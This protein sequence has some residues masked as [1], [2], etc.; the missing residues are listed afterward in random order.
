MT[1]LPVAFS[2]LFDSAVS[3]AAK[4]C[5]W[6]IPMLATAGATAYISYI[7]SQKSNT[8]LVV[9]QQRL[10][11]LQQFRSSG[12]ELDQGLSAMSD[13]LVDGSGLDEAR[14][15]M[16]GA[17]TKNI[18]DAVAIRHLLGP[19][20]DTYIAGLARLRQVVDKTNDV[21]AGRDLWQTSIDLM[22]ER[23]TLLSSAQVEALRADQT[24]K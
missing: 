12:A 16:R 13:A 18:A 21:H 5:A 22:V 20:A 17:I 9:Q 8:A 1:T 19:K 10:N 3:G 24:A 11:D 15:Q 4:A 6:L 7:Y 14:K 23:R 2:R